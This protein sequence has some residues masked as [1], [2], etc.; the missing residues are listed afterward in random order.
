[1]IFEKS[2]LPNFILIFELWNNDKNLFQRSMAFSFF[3][4]HLK[5]RIVNK[6]VR[7]QPEKNLV[8]KKLNIY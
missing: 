3:Y 2:L 4:H 5:S 7:R 1:M 8:D 6:K